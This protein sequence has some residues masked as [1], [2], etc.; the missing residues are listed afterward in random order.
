MDDKTALPL[1]H[2]KYIR[3]CFRDITMLIH[4]AAGHLWGG[5]GA[6]RGWA[7]RGVTYIARGQ[8]HSSSSAV[9]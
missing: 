6:R 2:S 7:V 4:R 3:H 8:K 1:S 5:A 9:M